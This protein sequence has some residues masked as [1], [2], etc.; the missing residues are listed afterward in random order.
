MKKSENMLD[1]MQKKMI[2]PILWILSVSVLSMDSRWSLLILLIN[3]IAL[4]AAVSYWRQHKVSEVESQTETTA[5]TAEE[6][7]L[8]AYREIFETVG[9]AMVILDE[10]K[11]IQLVNRQFLNLVNVPDM[12]A[13][14]DM[15][16]GRYIYQSDAANVLQYMNE[17]LNGE[18]PI[19]TRDQPIEFRFVNQEMQISHVEVII[20]KI[21]E[22]KELIVSLL[23]VTEKKEAYKKLEHFATHDKLTELANR[24]YFMEK[25]EVAMAKAS[26]NKEM[27][28]I[29]YIDIDDFKLI[30]D[31]YG[32]HVGD[33]VL[34]ELADRVQMNIPY[35]DLAAR[36]GGDEFVVMLSKESSEDYFRKIATDIMRS[37]QEPFN[38]GD[39]RIMLTVSIGLSMFPKDGTHL[40]ELIRSADHAMYEVKH[41]GKNDIGI[42][43]VR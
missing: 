7:I 11:L 14:K 1:L 38:L 15:P 27:L 37:L 24:H 29:L 5:N 22:S 12:D 4:Y 6:Q 3:C 21:E 28:G 25:L 36:M 19:E 10:N 42:Y 31:L 35:G 8:F 30:N 13:I 9:T 41:N 32:H 2:Y 40:L 18:H 23:D 39:E 43:E 20:S 16:F 34:H 17:S 26:K 33:D